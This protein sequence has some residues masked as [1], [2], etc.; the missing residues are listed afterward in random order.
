MKKVTGLTFFCFL[1]ALSLRAQNCQSLDT[2]K[3][4]ATFENVYNRPLYSDSL[5][6]SFVIFVKKEVKPHVHAYHTEQVIVL[7]GEGEMTIGDKKMTI[8]KGDILFIPKN[9]VHSLKVTSKDPV[10]VISI[11][12]PHFDGKD[13]VMINQNDPK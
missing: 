8:K 4:P 1:L 5:V 10:K 3:P 9:T 2:L 13:R 6:S 11:Q 7:E 12:A